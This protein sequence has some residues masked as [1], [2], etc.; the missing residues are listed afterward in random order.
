MVHLPVKKPHDTQSH[1]ST[2]TLTAK[3]NAASQTLSVVLKRCPSSQPPHS[4]EQLE[5]EEAPGEE[6]FVAERG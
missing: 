5:T 2:H 3:H 4:H 6:K 1:H